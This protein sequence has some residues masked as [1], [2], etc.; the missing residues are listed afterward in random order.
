MEKKDWKCVTPSSQ[1]QTD[2]QTYLS[3]PTHLPSQASYEGFITLATTSVVENGCFI[4]LAQSNI[5]HGHFVCGTTTGKR[6]RRGGVDRKGG[7]GEWTQSNP[8]AYSYYCTHIDCYIRNLGTIMKPDR[9][10]LLGKQI[11]II[12]NHT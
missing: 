2:R 11:I 12:T 1:L 6:G 10:W 4:F 9:Y 7:K 3:H 8:N 5:Q